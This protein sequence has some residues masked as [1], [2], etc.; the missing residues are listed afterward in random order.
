MGASG[1]FAVAGPV[2]LAVGAGVGGYFLYQYM[3]DESADN[4]TKS[5]K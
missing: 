4:K 2:G 3:T 5:D 1:V